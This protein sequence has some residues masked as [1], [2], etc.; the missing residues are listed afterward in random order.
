MSVTV[1]NPLQALSIGQTPV[2]EFEPAFGAPD[3]TRKAIEV[4][5]LVWMPPNH[6][7]RRMSEVE[8]Y[9][10]TD[11]A[12]RK[13]ERSPAQPP[14]HKP[15]QGDETGNR[16]DQECGIDKEHLP[17]RRSST[18]SFRNPP[19]L[20]GNLNVGAVYRMARCGSLERGPS[21]A[22]WMSTDCVDA[23]R[24]P[25]PVPPYPASGQTL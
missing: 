6:E 18:L 13:P 19:R 9:E 5:V 22:R 21:R 8:Y 7:N 12:R 2:V 25:G 10:K 15:E 24:D 11:H 17:P 16:Y 3:P 20:V 14:P 1:K 4:E 23:F